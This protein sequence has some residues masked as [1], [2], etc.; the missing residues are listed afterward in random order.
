M[1]TDRRLSHAALGDRLYLSEVT[2]KS[3]MLGQPRPQQDDE[4]LT[5]NR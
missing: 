4:N 2:V 1:S 5:V 3:P